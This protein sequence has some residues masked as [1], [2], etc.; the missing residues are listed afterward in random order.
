[1]IAILY[2]CVIVAELRGLGGSRNQKISASSLRSLG[3]F[4]AGVLLRRSR[5]IDDRQTLNVDYHVRGRSFARFYTDI[6]PFSIFQSCFM[7]IH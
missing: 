6:V 1:V 5:L 4:G 2:V 7:G 3:L